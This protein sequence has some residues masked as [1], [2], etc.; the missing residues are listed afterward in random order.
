MVRVTR[1]ILCSAILC[2]FFFFQYC[3]AQSV[4]N[5]SDPVLEYDATH[6]PTPPD[7]FHPLVKWVRTLNVANG[8]VQSRNPDW[9]SDVYKAYNYNGLSFRVQFP[10]TYS[11]GINDG[12]KYPLIIF[13]HGQGENDNTY[14]GPQPPG[15]GSYNYDNQFQLLQGP[16]Q[17]DN[18]IKNGQYDGYVIVPQLQNNASSYPTVFYAGILN[19][20][21]NIVK[22]MITNNKVDPFH[23]VV[24][25]LSEGGVGTWEM[26]NSYPTYISA[27]MPMS[28]PTAFVDWSNTGNYFKSKRFT[29]VWVSQGGQD[30]HP[31]PAETQRIA[32]TM[33]K[34]GA[35]FKESF[36]P[37][38]GHNTW[39]NFWG[40][41][42]FWPFIN[43]AYSSN[44]WMIGGL[45]TY[46]SGQAISDT[47]G[48]APGFSAYQWRLNGN[49]ISGATTN[50]LYVTAPGVYDARV[51]RDGIWSDWSHVPINIITGS[52]AP[53]PSSSVIHIEAENYSN[54]SGVVKENT[55]DAGGGQNVGYIDLGD[56]MDY[57]ITVPSSGSF[58]V[59]LRVA[60]PSGGQLQIKSSGGS[61]LA[62]VAIPATGGWQNWQT[63]STTITLPQGS[64]TLRIYSASNGWNFNWMDII[65]GTTSTPPPSSTTTR[66]EAETYTSMS[67]VVKETTTDVGG[68]QSIG[69]IDTGDWMDYSISVSSSGSYAVNLRVASPLGGQL[70]IKNSAGTILATVTVPNTGDWQAWQTVNT[71]ITLA[72]GT[73]TIR[74]YSASNG[75]NFNW[76]EIGGVGGTVSAASV[77]KVQITPATPSTS[78]ELLSFYPNPFAS[79]FQLQISNELT[80]RVSVELYNASGILQKQLALSKPDKGR[81]QYY[82]SLGQVPAGNYIIKVV[83]DGWMKSEK[84]I[85]Q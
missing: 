22:Y 71:N 28:S 27:I 36:Y 59:N 51:Q 5:P 44:P 82:L 85:K 47:I 75:W 84:I 3:E 6:P 38:D 53:P 74:I 77:S 55:T 48:I 19:D 32:D 17:F 43:N 65:G 60:S 31:T 1:R 39:Y 15:S 80:G 69:Y 21:M 7:Y 70:Q 35:N 79:G 72:A 10:K 25:G 26:L 14:L 50:I 29:P 73:Q 78:G 56:W 18:A 40:E 49:V 58:S 4:I 2:S 42:N 62:T 8:A 61:V 24:N 11:P 67:G 83:M 33:A 45:K 34:Y 41:S 76:F 20:I 57:N 81:V 37:T 52:T 54:M 13:L 63:V 9:N 46:A 64:Q 30:T 12:K 23:I 66:I 16:P 68:G